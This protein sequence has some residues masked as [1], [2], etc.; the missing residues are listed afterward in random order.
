MVELFLCHENTLGHWLDECSCLWW[1]D[2][3]SNTSIITHQL[4]LGWMCKG[5]VKE[6]EL[7]YLVMWNFSTWWVITWS[8]QELCSS[9]LATI[10][11][12]VSALRKP[13]FSLLVLPLLHLLPFHQVIPVEGKQ[14]R[15]PPVPT[16]S[17][18]KL[19]VTNMATPLHCMWLFHTATQ[20][21]GT[22]MWYNHVILP[23]AQILLDS[24]LLHILSSIH[25]QV[26]LLNG[27]DWTPHI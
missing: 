19:L 27:S 3:A 15:K 12:L 20:P 7:L 6:E 8:T 13:L 25:H 18:I 9:P 1:Q 11:V 22:T 16:T 17:S 21:C 14:W 2:H 10:F 26:A 23:P 24:S 5:I 4:W